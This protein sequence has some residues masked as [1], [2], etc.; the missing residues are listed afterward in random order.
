MTPAISSADAGLT[1]T[2]G[3]LDVID[4]SGYSADRTYTL[5]GTAAAGDVCGVSLSTGD[6]TYELLIT[7]TAGDTL[8]GIAGGTEWSRIFITGEIVTFI[9]TVANTTWLVLEDGRIPMLATLSLTTQTNL[10]QTALTYYLPT[11]VAGVWTSVVDRGNIVTVATGMITS[12]RACDAI[13]TSIAA[14]RTTVTD[15]KWWGTGI[16]LNGTVTFV[17]GLAI[18]QIAAATSGVVQ[19]RAASSVRLD[20]SDTLQLQFRG[21]EANRGMSAAGTAHQFAL[22]E[23]L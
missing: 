7:A 18:V 5:P 3:Q 14:P 16:S 17:A 2:V 10:T 15:Q 12:R 8:N 23:V 9:C 13:V 20:A 6:A 1:G 19:I 4:I 22:A 21:E 11:S